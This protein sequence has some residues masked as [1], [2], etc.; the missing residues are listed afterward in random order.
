MLSALLFGISGAS[1]LLATPVA[2]VAAA[3][4]RAHAV[5]VDLGGVDVATAGPAAAGV[6]ALGG[7]GYFVKQKADEEAA[8]KEYQR[9]LAKEAEFLAMKS[10]DKSA[11]LISLYLP[12]AISV[13]FA[14]WLVKEF[15][16]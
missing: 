4:A 12:G 7:G 10:R 8:E 11:A 1:A 14:G 3:P 5:A 2:R 9:Q 6:L 13:A 15:V 16:A